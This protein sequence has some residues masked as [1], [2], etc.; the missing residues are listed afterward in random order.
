M[1]ELSA[2]MATPEFLCACANVRRAS[3]AVCHLYDLVLAPL[4]L[5]AT[6]FSM[7]QAIAGAGEIAHCDLARQSAASEETFS[8][9]LASARKN[10]WVS[11]R[12]GNQQRR[13]Y[14]L[15]EEGLAVYRAALPHWERAQERMRRELGDIEWQKLIGF[16]DRLT[17]AAIRAESAPVRNA[18]PRSAAE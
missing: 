7:L 3:R 5:K 9:R 4:Q 15:T 6:Q 11:M 16:A 14:Q 1:P 13:L 8:R 18:R 2:L 17:Q 10:G 12:I